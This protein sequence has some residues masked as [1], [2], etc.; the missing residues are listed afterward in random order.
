MND[1]NIE[2]KNNTAVLRLNKE[3]YSPEAIFGAAHIMTDKCYVLVDC[4]SSHYI[5]KVSGK[6]RSGDVENLAK[7]YTNEL[8]NFVVN[9]QKTEEMYEFRNL[10]MRK[11]QDAQMDV[12][13]EK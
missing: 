6:K 3:M 1:E 8:V 5:V 12:K 11:I 10:I 2:I 13:K 4:D 7:E 9:S